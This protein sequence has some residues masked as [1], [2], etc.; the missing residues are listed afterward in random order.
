MNFVQKKT[1]GPQVAG[2]I[3][4][5]AE[6][7]LGTKEEQARGIP[8]YIIHKVNPSETLDRISII[9]NVPKDAI[10]KANGF[11]GDEIYMKKELIIPNASGPVFRVDN[12]LQSEEQR[13]KDLIDLM[14]LH[15]KERFKDQKSY[16]A[17]A[18][19]YLDITNYNY[20]KAI[21]EFEEDLKFEKEQ[22]TK[23]KGMKGPDKGK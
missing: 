1:V 18:Q 17:E 4:I 10:R 2:A 5:E 15:L 20:E 9:Q 22:E 16:K 7:P 21:L 19:Y 8:N 13:K 6:I 14:S 12:P 11:T 23:F 3:S